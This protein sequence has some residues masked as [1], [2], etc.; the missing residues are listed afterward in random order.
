VVYGFE[1]IISFTFSTKKESINTDNQ[2]EESSTGLVPRVECKGCC[3]FSFSIK[4][5]L[6][7]KPK[8]VKNILTFHKIPT[9]EIGLMVPPPQFGYRQKI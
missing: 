1:T 5:K 4:K 7:P 8:C 2:R 6:F 3:R 9:E